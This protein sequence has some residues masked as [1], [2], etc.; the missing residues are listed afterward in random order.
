[1]NA[2]ELVAAAL[3][4]VPGV[5][6]HPVQPAS[7]SPGQA[8][9]EWRRTAYTDSCG[10]IP[11]PADWEVVLVLPALDPTAVDDL[12]DEV[13]AALSTVAETTEAVPDTVQLQA[14]GT[15][16]PAIRFTISI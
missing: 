6:G 16:A 8:W 11:D 12:R 9:P 5:T 4:T 14:D 13:A 10:A 3:S 15:G 1:M 7:P 2:R